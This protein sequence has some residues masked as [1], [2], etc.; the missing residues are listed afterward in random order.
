MMK[1]EEQEEVD[2]AVRA[3][4]GDLDALSALVERLRLRLFA[5]AYAEVRHY[6]DAQ[7][8][9]AS[10]LVRI[11]SHIGELREVGRLR[12]WMDSI[13]RN[14]ARRIRSRRIAAA[15]HVSL[16][17]AADLQAPPDNSALH[18]DVERTLRGLPI[19]QAHA[20]SLFYLA[21]LPVREIAQRTGRPEGTIKS[22]L[23][24]GR[25][26]LARSLKEYAPMTA[27]EWTAA[28]VSDSPDRTVI[29]SLSNALR[30]AGFS[31]IH[32]FDDYSKV[33][34]TSGFS[35]PKTGAGDAK[36]SSL[37]EALRDTHLVILDEHVGRHSA[38]E[39]NL[40]LRAAE[41]ADNV[42]MAHCILLD[43]FDPADE[44]TSRISVYASWL[45]G[46]ELCLTKPVNP[47]DFANL[48]KRVRRSMDGA[49]EP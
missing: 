7:D 43:P 42:T 47:D 5:I 12:V 11:C 16:Q 38:F 49:E 18:L 36:T 35:V 31:R 10:A 45:S 28:I 14:E 23:H 20:L 24:H 21:G 29:E 44:E 2:L 17:D 22:R 15:A 32:L 27:I 6:E 48:A 25:R 37:P 41:K 3:R 46:F 19:D 26:Q 34:S 9:V 13:V 30:T 40:I 1:P 4:D 33:V 39:I 8:A